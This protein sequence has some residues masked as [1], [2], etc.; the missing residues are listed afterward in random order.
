MD[1][2]EV[3]KAA[4]AAVVLPEPELPQD[5]WLGWRVDGARVSE[6]LEELAGI[7]ATPDGGVNRIGFSDGEIQAREWVQPIMRAAGL[8]V[9]IDPAGNVI[10]TRPGS[11][12]SLAP[13]LVGSHVDS[14]P[15]GGRY[16]GSLGTLSAIEVAR[17]LA[18]KRYSNRHPLWVA[19]WCDEE[20]GLT[21]SRGFIGAIGPE[22]LAAPRAPGEPPL[23]D[24]LRRIGGDPGAMGSYRNQ[25]G[26]IAGY[27]E[28]HIEQGGILDRAGI[29]IG[30]VEGIVGIRSAEVTITG[31]TNHAGTTPMDQ[32][33][34]ALLAAAEVALAVERIVRSRPGLQ[35]GT[36]GQLTVK[37]GARNAIAGQAALSIEIRDL[38][39]PLLDHLWAEIEAAGRDI[40]AR[41][42][43]SWTVDFRPTNV[44]ALSDAGVRD[45]IDRAARSLGLTT[46]S[47]P[48]G[49]GHDAQS[50]ARIGPMGMIFVPSVGGISH[51]PAEFT[52]PEDV[53]NGANVLLQT[54][55]RLD[56]AGADPR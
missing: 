48:S 6:W 51:A 40:M 25:P 12:P 3:A 4:T 36:V 16:D 53:V 46:H 24:L 14:V 21:G 17:T 19:V 42:G 22:E 10:G 8:E 54:V 20:R 23:G 30:V 47:M 50:L 13:L 26:S 1:R 43:T 31:S 9:R 52:R 37:P 56:R 55:L 38:S 39:M 45:A 35:V 2:R 44:A 49:A 7:G 18:E 32:R 33:R 5:P 41:R 15:N 34:D 27:V 11:D 28:L 29:E